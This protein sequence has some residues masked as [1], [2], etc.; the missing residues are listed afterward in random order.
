[1]A[2][3]TAFAEETDPTVRAEIESALAARATRS[4]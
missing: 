2:L 1:V 3:E 4:E